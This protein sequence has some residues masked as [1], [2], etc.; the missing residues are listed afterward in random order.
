MQSQRLYYLLTCMGKRRTKSNN[1]NRH[2]RN[3]FRYTQQIVIILCKKTILS[4]TF[5][6][7]NWSYIMNWVESAILQCTKKTYRCMYVS[8]N[9][10][11]LPYLGRRN[12]SDF[13]DDRSSDH[14]PSDSPFNTLHNTKFS[15]L[16]LVLYRLSLTFTCF[17]IYLFNL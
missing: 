16:S 1:R 2:V 9:V 11:D 8:K 14:D 4:S 15:H 6:N 13:S 17:M 3:R 10:S 5:I 12:S 7:P